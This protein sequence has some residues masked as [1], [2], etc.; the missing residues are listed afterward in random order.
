MET[1]FPVIRAGDPGTWLPMI[2]IVILCVAVLARVWVRI[3]DVHHAERQDPPPEKLTRSVRILLETLGATAVLFFLFLK[4]IGG[5][6]PFDGPEGPVR[7]AAFFAVA[8][9][10]GVAAQFRWDRAKHYT[11]ALAV[12]TLITFVLLGFKRVLFSVAAPQDPFFMALGIICV[13]LAWRFLF[14]PWRPQVKATVL[15]TFIFWVGVHLFWR[16]A[17][18]MR[19]AHLLAV[20][21]AIIPAIV[22]CLLFLH[23]HRQRL[24][25]V[26]LMFLAGMLSTAP[27]LFYDALVRRGAEFQ[28]FLFRIT[29]ENFTRTSTAF[30]TGNLVGLPSIKTTLAATLLSFLIVGVIEETSKYWVLK[31]SGERFFA[32]ID[33]VMQ[34]GIIVAIGFAFAENVMNP[35]YFVSFVREYIIT[36]ESPNWGGFIGNVLGRAILTNMVHILSTG[37]VG[38][39]YGLA[40]FAGPYLEET[41]RE[42]LGHPLASFFNRLFRLPTKAVFRRQMMAIGLLSAFVLHGMFNFLVTL[43]D[44]LPG[45]PRTLG[46]LLGSPPGSF[47]HM[48]AL[49]IVPSLFYVVGGFWILSVL[50]FRKECMKE[51]GCLVEVDTFVR[52]ERVLA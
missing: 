5:I 22:W 19:T 6:A 9:G 8:A 46:D 21:V 36:P 45:N 41:A 37:V 44:L 1:N 33:D 24:S 23:E 48:I 7:A 40:L 52:Q 42:G 43:P 49:L 34:L 17:P 32:S 10:V 13:V 50:L 26:I 38:Y 16:E 30:V 11:F 20:I 4:T 18:A 39:F 14:G 12:G 31:R 15:A 25:L 47:L 28:F 51:R 27:I 35:T 29:P 2:G 3:R